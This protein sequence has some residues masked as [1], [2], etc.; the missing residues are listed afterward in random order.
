MIFAGFETAWLGNIMEK[1]SGHD[2]API[3]VDAGS[4]ET[5][6]QD[7]RHL[8]DHVGMIA[9]MLRHIRGT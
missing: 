4:D 2:K 6:G 1:G 9:N 3:K 5:V 7:K 8:A